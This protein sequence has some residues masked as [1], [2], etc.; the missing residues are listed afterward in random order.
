[1]SILPRATA[2][3]R[4]GRRRDVQPTGTRAAPPAYRV[5]DYLTDGARLFRVDGSK[6]DP[7]SGARVLA[8]EDCLTLDLIHCPADAIPPRALR[9]VSSTGA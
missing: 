8:L 5:G 9:T 2:A 3:D 7:P 6:I 4:L 1:M